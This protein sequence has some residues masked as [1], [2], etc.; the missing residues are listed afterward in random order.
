MIGLVVLLGGLVLVVTTITM[1]DFWT[2]RR[3]RR[4][5]HAR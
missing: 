1:L 2:R 5:P 3:D 4:K